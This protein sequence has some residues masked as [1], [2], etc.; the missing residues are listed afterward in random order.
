MMP[1]VVVLAGS[2]N[3][4]SRANRIAAWCAQRCADLG[5]TSSLFRG[6]D[7]EFP[8]YRPG[9]VARH[10]AARRY[11]DALRKA[12]GVVLVSPTYHGTPSGLLKNALDYVN[13]LADD[14]EP[15]LDGRSIGCVALAGGDQGAHSTVAALRTIGHALRG[16]PTPLGIALSTDT[17]AVDENGQPLS[18]RTQ[19]QLNT[20]VGQVWEVAQ[21]R[22]ADRGIRCLA[23][24]SYQSPLPEIL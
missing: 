13:E 9:V 1:H 4:T 21:R 22:A 10:A 2:L 3:P 17:S 19:W 23:A 6:L 12:D 7:L 20:M 16:W 18:P 11:L 15:Y 14:S 24:A 8:F 5:A